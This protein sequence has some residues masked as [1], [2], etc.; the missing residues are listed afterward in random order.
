MGRAGPP[1]VRIPGGGRVAR[2][3]GAVRSRGVSCGQL[4]LFAALLFGIVTMHTVGIATG[5]R[6]RRPADRERGRARR[7]RTP[8]ELDGNWWRRGGWPRTVGALG[9]RAPDR[10]IRMRLTGGMAAYDWAFDGR[11]YD[12]KERRP[13]EAGERVRLVFD[14]ATAMWHP[15]HVHGH[16]FALG[17]NAAGARKDTAIVLPHRSLTVEFDADN[18]GLWMVHCHNVYHAEAGMMTVLGYRA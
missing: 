15:L 10:T 18:P 4:V 17:G 7:L 14:N 1:L 13:V 9:G 12:A 8:K 2:M 5:G 16:T 6:P 3:A 11:P